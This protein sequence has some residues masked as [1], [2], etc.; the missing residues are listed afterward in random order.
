MKKISLI[1]VL[2]ILSHVAIAQKSYTIHDWKG[3]VLIKEYKGQQWLP[4]KK[5]Q[6]VSGLDS[7]AIDKNGILRIIDNQSNLIYKSV[8]VGKMRVLNVINDVK[9]QNSNILAAVNRELLNGMKGS[10]KTNTM[11]LVGA[12][13]RGSDDETFMDSIAQTFGWLANMAIQ[14]KLARTSSDLLLKSY[15]TSDGIWFEIQNFSKKNYFVNVLH[16]NK[17]TKKVNLCY[18]IEQTQ[19]SET[20]FLYL[21][22]GEHMQLKNFVFSNDTSN[23]VYILVGTEDQYIPEQLQNNLRHLDIETAQPLYKKYEYSKNSVL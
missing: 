22:Y 16:I 20:P 7:I 15:N 1:L 3:K 9:K 19:E 23:D 8:S 5:N 12:T 4:I 18:I 11:Q 13:T 10:S 17:Q 2:C 14:D 21:P 6:A